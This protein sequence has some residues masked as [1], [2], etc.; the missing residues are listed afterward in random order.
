MNEKVLELIANFEDFFK[1]EKK[2]NCDCAY[3]KELLELVDKFSYEYSL[4]VENEI[5]RKGEK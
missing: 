4:A 3:T 5:M 1:Y 2:I